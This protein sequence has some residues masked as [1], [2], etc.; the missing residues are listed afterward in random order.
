M[1]RVIYVEVSDA[2]LC[3]CRGT[4]EGHQHFGRSG[5]I[6]QRA[7]AASVQV[8][9]RTLQNGVEL[10]RTGCCLL[11]VGALAPLVL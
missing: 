11:A 7:L 10:C 9:H 5:G 4:V 6:F 8:V 2:G 3:Q 1:I